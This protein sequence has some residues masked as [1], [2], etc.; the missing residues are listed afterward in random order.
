MLTSRA[1]YL[2]FKC[3]YEYNIRKMFRELYS[4]FFNIGTKHI[5][6]ATSYLQE[7]KLRV[8][9]RD[10]IE[11][12][13][14]FMSYIIMIILIAGK[15]ARLN[16]SCLYKFFGSRSSLMLK[17]RKKYA[18]GMFVDPKSPDI[19]SFM[20]SKKFVCLDFLRILEQFRLDRKEIE[21]ILGFADL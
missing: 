16:Y 14:T 12:L 1:N 9:N 10:S 13:N 18:L 17:D 21:V 5:K 3:M 20:T 6:K 2:R 4:I 15:L 19:N 7:K 11:E 8:A